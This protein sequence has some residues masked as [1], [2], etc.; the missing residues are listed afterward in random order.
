MAKTKHRFNNCESLNRLIDEYFER[1]KNDTGKNAEP[2]TLTG[3]AIFL[4]FTSKEVFDQ[5]EQIVKYKESLMRARFR[6]MAYYESRLHFP[7]PSG[8]IFALKSMGWD[9]KVKDTRSGAKPQSLTVKVIET[10]PK[11]AS[12][13]KEVA[14]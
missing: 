10:G 7:S 9:E 1:S 8:A 12:A 5:Y 6:I 4:G 11:P 13:E 2:V 3:L 14:L